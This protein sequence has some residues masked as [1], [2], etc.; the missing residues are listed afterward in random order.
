[1]REPWSPQLLSRPST[2]KPKTPRALCPK[3]WSKPRVSLV[4]DPSHFKTPENNEPPM[5]TVRLLSLILL[6]AALALVLPALK[7]DMLGYWQRIQVLR[8]R[9]RQ[10]TAELYRLYGY[11]D[12]NFE[13]HLDGKRIYRS[14]DCAPDATLPF[15]ET[16]AW[17]VSGKVLLFQ[18]AGETVFAYDLPAG[19]EISAHELCTI[20]VPQI[21]LEE[22]AFEG[23]QKVR[24]G[25]PR[26]IQKNGASSG[27]QPLRVDAERTPPAAV[28]GR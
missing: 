12:A 1:M 3:K 4:L 28:C 7:R 23:L 13:I 16:L 24:L 6:G 26:N 9:D 18:L 5:K 21:T 11:I 15:R 20:A 19:A 22:I 27:A 8:S 10:H 2:T 25:N 14:P 17:D